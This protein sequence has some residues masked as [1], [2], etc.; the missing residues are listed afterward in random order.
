MTFNLY[1]F[2]SQVIP[3]FVVYLSLI[4]MFGIPWDKDYVIA[5]TVLAFLT[6]Y[7]VNAIG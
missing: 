5:A 1:D 4:R 3:G 6:G 2:L 7:F